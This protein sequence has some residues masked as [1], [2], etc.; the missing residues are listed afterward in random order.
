MEPVYLAM[1]EL[2]QVKDILSGMCVYG[3]AHRRVVGTDRYRNAG[4]LPIE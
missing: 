4:H 1:A 3:V 2:K